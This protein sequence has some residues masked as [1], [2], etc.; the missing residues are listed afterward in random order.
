MKI[1]CS[2]GICLLFG[3]FACDS[4][5]DEK[6][7]KSIVVITSLKDVRSLLDNSVVFNRQGMLTG[8]SSDEFYITPAGLVPL[9]VTEKRTYLWMDDPFQGEMVNDWVTPYQQ[10]FYANVA[11]ETLDDI[12]VDASAAIG[13][14]RGEALF[15][16]SFAYFNLLQQFAPAYRLD[17]DN[18]GL[19]GIVLK[20]SAEVNE[21]A[22]RYSLQE[23][24]DQ[25]EEDLLEAVDLLPAT[26]L[27]KTRPNKAAALGLLAR[28]Y[29]VA[30]DFEGAAETALA[31]LDYYEARL[32]FNE[33]DVDARF[34]FQTFGDETIFY[35][36]QSSTRL[37]ISREA[38]VAE[39]LTELFKE[40]DLRIPAYFDE[41]DSGR[42]LYSGKHSGNVSFFGGI[43]VGELELTAAEALARVGSYT[44]ALEILNG[45][46][47]R[48][49][50]PEYYEPA[51]Q[52]GL[53]L[54]K[55]I[56]DER[57]LELF[58]R[59]IRWFDLRRLN[60]EPEFETVFVRERD[61]NAISILP[62]SPKYVFPI[63][64]LEIERNG[65]EQN[66]R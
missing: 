27:Y 46:L 14:L 23:C 26:G 25:I 40:G 65:I 51:N 34:P 48:R 39:E 36:V 6:P 29:L 59:G 55:K 64:D 13:E 1:K 21:P 32:D 38:F 45:F 60:Q 24:Y 41:V 62:N 49:F 50:S 15:H 52:S 44:E 43:S 9:N 47:A 30:F 17:G 18:T 56:I 8:R 53:E 3:L 66:E 58:G 54:V 12:K 42:Y 4:F 5:L 33:I 16:R 19:L 10:V 63:P 11:L 28:I 37:N 7:D 57:K 35:S 61:G 2:I 31:A 20:Q 22:V